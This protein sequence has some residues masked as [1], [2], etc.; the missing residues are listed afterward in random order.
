MFVLKLVEGEHRPLFLSRDYP[1]VTWVGERAR[2]KRYRT[3]EEAQ[4]VADEFKG[5]G[6]VSVEPRGEP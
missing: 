4:R 3:Q 1:H 2:A 5:Y 6:A